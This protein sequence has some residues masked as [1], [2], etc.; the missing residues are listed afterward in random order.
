MLIKTAMRLETSALFVLG[1]SEVVI[2][3]NG[4]TIPG[5]FPRAPP[6]LRGGYG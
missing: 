5:P 6:R 2:D 4:F 1:A 3:L